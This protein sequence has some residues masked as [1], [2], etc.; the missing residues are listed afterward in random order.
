MP[1]ATFTN[2]ISISMKKFKSFLT[3]S[4]ADRKQI[5]D[6]V[7]S[8][9]AINIVFEKI[10]KDMRELGASINADNSTVYSLNQT[11]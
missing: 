5:I 10:K 6:R 1:Q 4:P 8:L 9:E 7:F 3:M 2:M 11:V